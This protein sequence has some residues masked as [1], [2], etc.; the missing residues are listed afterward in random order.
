MV[1]DQTTNLN[2]M[3][4]VASSGLSL[5]QTSQEIQHQEQ[6]KKSYCSLFVIF[7]LNATEFVKNNL[8]KEQYDVLGS[9]PNL[10]QHPEVASEHKFVQD[11][12]MI[13]FPELNLKT[14]R[15][16]MSNM[17][18]LCRC[19][20]F[21]FISTN[22]MGDKK[23]LTSVHFKEILLCEKGAFVIDK[24]VCVASSQ[25]IFS[26]QKQVL[27]QIFQKVVLQNNNVSIKAFKQAQWTYDGFLDEYDQPPPHDFPNFVY[28]FMMDQVMCADNRKAR[29]RD[30]DC[31]STSPP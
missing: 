17:D 16:K 26:L 27:H 6:Q 28:K 31:H 24:A 21:H 20:F 23:Y 18:P 25:P 30:S 5:V 14:E 15:F 7:G 19:Q 4:T 29:D 3:Q 13:C 11:L 9:Y 12:R 1:S 10:D 2:L 22:D 8:L